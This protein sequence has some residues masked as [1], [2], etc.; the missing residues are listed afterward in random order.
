MKGHV[1][2]RGA[3]NWYAVIDVRDPQTG[4]RKR[5]WHSL[6]D[7][8]GKREAQ[9]EC[10]RI[11]SDLK[12]GSYLEP[13][14]TTVT[15]FLDRWLEHIR[16]QVSPKS[17][18]R[19]SEIVKKNLA[20]L[21]GAVILSK[22]QA[23]QID[24]AYSKA[25]REGRRDGKGGL[26][27]R[28]VH[29]M[30]RVL[31]QALGQGV[32]WQVLNRNP[33]DAAQPPKVERQALD[34]LSMEQTATVLD[35]LRE[36]RLF[37]P[38]M[39]GVLCG[40]RRGEI[41]ALRW[42]SV[43]LDKGALAV[44]ESAEQT[45]TGVRYKEPK[46]GRSRTVALSETVVEELQAWRARQAQEFLRLGLR[47]DGNTFVVTQADSKPLQPNSLTHEWVRLAAA[48]KLPDVRFHDLRHSHATHLLAANIHP[49]VASERLGH[50][51]VG[52]TLDLYSHVVPGMQ[53]DAAAKVDVA[54]RKALKR[55]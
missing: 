39:I 9:T 15:Q 42:K 50:S 7:C 25:L 23:A 28:T 10:A 2:E 41:V 44:V 52:I 46:S 40:L 30:H 37:V 31:K 8:K 24:A 45:K 49:K 47:P 29:H 55:A 12:G 26:S 21:L 14:K 17:H 18:E 13:S 53:E 11:I 34:T 1:R 48:K 27:P 36:T 22:L 5:K 16:R 38:V 4:K 51:K 19:Y 32:R 20:P 43:D 54:L 35:A 6:P 33:A 3:G